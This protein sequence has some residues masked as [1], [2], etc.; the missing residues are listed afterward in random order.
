VPVSCLS[1][2]VEMPKAREDKRRKRRN[3]KRNEQR[4]GWIVAHPSIFETETAGFG[5]GLIDNFSLITFSLNLPSSGI[6]I[7][8]DVDGLL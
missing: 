7:W 4:K 8:Q 5:F 2:V 3:A 6:L 1:K